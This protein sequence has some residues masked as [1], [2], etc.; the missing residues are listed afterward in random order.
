[1]N[2]ITSISDWITIIQ[3]IS[4]LGFCGYSLFYSIKWVIDIRKKYTILVVLVK[5][6]HGVISLVWIGVYGNSL[7]R[8][9][10]ENPIDVNPYGI[11]I[12]R[13]AIV[14]TSIYLAVAAKVRYYM[15]KH[16]EDSCLMRQ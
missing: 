12:V 11:N 2:I 8:I 9:L 13:P 4:I 10:L 1:M 7:V 14:L 16:K 15:A 3:Y 6:F 5:T